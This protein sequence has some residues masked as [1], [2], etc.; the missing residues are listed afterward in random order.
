MLPVINM[1]SELGARF[2]KL[3]YMQLLGELLDRHLSEGDLI[4]YLF[5]PYN[6]WTTEC[7]NK[8]CESHEG[9]DFFC[10]SNSDGPHG[11]QK[12]GLVRLGALAQARGATLVLTTGVYK[13]DV[14]VDK[15][16]A[17]YKKKKRVHVSSSAV[18]QADVQLQEKLLREVAA[19][20]E[21]V[22]HWSFSHHFCGAAYCSDRIPGT[23]HLIITRN[24]DWAHPTVQAEAY[25]APFLCEFLKK[26]ALL[27]S[28]MRHPH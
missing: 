6:T 16:R 4:F 10:C 5:M 14:L 21:S 12:A 9:K 18:F 24:W 26:N 8:R 7:K 13:N 28:T 22:L 15:E 17:F 20:E 19:E 25:S 23:S 27:Q 2:Y 1:V 3:K 11:P